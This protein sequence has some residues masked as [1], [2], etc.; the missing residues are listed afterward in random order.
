MFISSME[1]KIDNFRLSGDEFFYDVNLKNNG[2]IVSPNF[3]LYVVKFAIVL[4]MHVQ[5][6]P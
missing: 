6:L 5:H 3:L 1:K 2:A 4:V